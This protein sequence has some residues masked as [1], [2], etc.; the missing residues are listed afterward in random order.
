MMVKQYIPSNLSSLQL[1]VLSSC[2]IVPLVILSIYFGGIP[3]FIFISVLLFISFDELSKMADKSPS[4][5]KDCAIGTAYLTVGLGALFLLRVLP[6]DALFTTLSLFFIIWACDTGAFIAGKTIGGKK[7]CPSI[8]PGKT[9]AGFIGGIT[10]GAGVAVL[11]QLA[12]DIY[13]TFSLAIIIGLSVGIA[14]QIGDLVISK[15]K[16][17]VDV[18]DTGRI[19][20]G[21][22]GILDRIDS[23]L[24]A[25]PLYMIF[26]FFMN[27]TVH[28]P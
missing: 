15:Y 6:E 7:L 11:C 3:F 24:L 4:K 27:E 21:H 13:I 8:S 14:G 17:Y 22:G 16:R 2:V 10:A 20:P 23:I 12:F 25:A 18:K 28:L 19:I 1:R 5:S 9:W 26:V